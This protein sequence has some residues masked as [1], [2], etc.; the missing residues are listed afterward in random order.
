MSVRRVLSLLFILLLGAASQNCGGSK[1]ITIKGVVIRPDNSRV[2][3]A[4]VRTKPESEIVYTNTDGEFAIS[5]GLQPGTYEFIAEDR[6]NEGRTR[7]PVQ[8]GRSKGAQYI[9]IKIGATLQ[10]QAM[11]PGDERLP[12]LIRGK[13]R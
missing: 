12:V 1:K 7:V 11:Q 13:K 2:Q 10:M 9:Y 5:L 6:G 3:G 8:F 4:E